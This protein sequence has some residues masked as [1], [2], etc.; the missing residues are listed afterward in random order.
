MLLPIQDG[1]R[2]GAAP[3]PRMSRRS[4]QTP[5]RSTR[6]SGCPPGLKYRRATPVAILWQKKQQQPHSRERMP[7]QTKVATSL[8]SRCH[9]RC[10]L[11]KAF[12]LSMA[13][14]CITPAIIIILHIVTVNARYTQPV[15][16]C[17]TCGF[18]NDCCTPY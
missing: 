4:R 12:S 10:F 18:S 11:S 8:L 16:Y 1:A 13:Y 3:F 6:S 9:F 17:L 14:T 15:A 5:V 2:K 7:Q